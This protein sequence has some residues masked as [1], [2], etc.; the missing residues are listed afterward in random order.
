M[1]WRW[2]LL[3]LAILLPACRSRDAASRFSSNLPL[4]TF[5]PPGVRPTTL[6]VTELAETPAA[7]TGKMVQVSGAYQRLPV[8]VCDDFSRPAPA[9]WLLV[10]GEAQIG[11]TGYDN[12]L[13]SLLPANVEITV[14][15]SWL[16]WI[17]PVGCGKGAP[18]QEIWYLAVEEIVSPMPLARMMVTPGGAVVGP[19]AEGEPGEDALTPVPT[20]TLI[21]VQTPTPASG[22]PAGT[23]GTPT[24]TRTLSPRTPTATTFATSTP[25]L[26]AE[27]SATPAEGTPTPSP[28]LEF[29]PTATI[30]GTQPAA[31]A[32]QTGVTPTPT[33]TESGTQ[34]NVVNKGSIG[35]LP[36]MDLS[37]FPNLALAMDRVGDNEAHRWEFT[38]QAGEVITVSAVAMPQA[39]I[40]LEIR[41]TNGDTLVSENSAPAGSVEMIAGM[42]VESGGT[43]RIL[44]QETGRQATHYALL[45]DKSSYTGDSVYNLAGLLRYN[46]SQAG[47]LPAN[48][49][50]IW[51][52]PGE[53]EDT[54]T[55]NLTPQGSADLLFHFYGP[56]GNPLLND[57]RD[58]SGGGQS[59]FLMNYSL[60][61]DGLYAVHVGETG[62]SEANYTLTVSAQ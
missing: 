55:I 11:A 50:H 57:Y 26:S 17:G 12:L 41:N 9:T 1:K 16:R 22:Y 29:S 3:L 61:D 34:V 49:D 48:N 58:D 18:R 14:A 15:G 43:L 4:A 60:P 24:P 40:R 8:L 2:F 37:D 13:R 7:Y 38:V 44:V 36:L 5:A 46:Q 35:D 62:L 20:A 45:L 52:F 21:T 56:T 51:I 59:E 19:T 33:A 23:P 25:D 42:N 53:G 30:S 10:D 39:N 27:A 31:T 28:T 47:S 54:V 6:T 32:T